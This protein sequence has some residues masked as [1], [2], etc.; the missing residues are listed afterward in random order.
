MRI[1]TNIS[2]HVQKFSDNFRTLPKISEDFPK[3]LKNQKHLKN[4][5]EPFSKFYEISVDFWTPQ[6]FTKFF[7]KFYKIIKLSEKHF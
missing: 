1:I 4:P 2:D 7:W 3:I 6:R 5:F